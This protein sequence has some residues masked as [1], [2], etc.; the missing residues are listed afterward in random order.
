MKKL[1][2]DRFIRVKGKPLYAKYPRG[3]KLL[4]FGQEGNTWGVVVWRIEEIIDGEGLE[5]EIGYG[6]NELSIVGDYYDGVDFG[7]TEYTVVA[8]QSINPKYGLQYELVSMIDN[9]DLTD[10]FQQR[11][12]LSNF[13]APSI[14]DALYQT[15]ESPMKAIENK[16]RQTLMKVKG[17]GPKIADKIL[18]KYAAHKD[19]SLI[20]IELDEYNFTVSFIK[21]LIDKYHNPR[22]AIAKVKTQPYDLIFELNG[23]GFK[24]A[25]EIAMKG[26]LDPTSPE[27]LKGFIYYY[28]TTE[29]D[30]GNSYVLANEL[31]S[32]IFNYFGGREEI[33]RFVKDEE[34]NIVDN[35]INQALT[36]LQEA[37]I[38]T[39]E[40]NAENK[41][42]RKIYLQYYYDLEKK[43]AFHLKRLLHAPNKFQY[44]HW[45]EAL[46][47]L[48]NKQGWKFTEEQ[49]Q[50]VKLALDSQVAFI[51]GGAGCGK[52]SLVSGVI[53]S[54][55]KYSFQQCSLAGK[56]AAR[57][58]E[59]T[60]QE[61]VTIHRLLKY[62]PIKGGFIH[63]N[64][65]PIV[66]DIIIV[67]EIS[68][69]GGEIFLKLLEAIADGTKL[70][71]LGDMGQ[72]E[73]IGCLNIAADIYN[74]N[75]IPKVEL[76]IIHRQ[77]QKSGIIT[78]SLKV[79][80]EESLFDRG[81]TGERVIG[82]LQDMI[83]I[84]NSSSGSSK[85][86]A[87]EAFKKYYA[88]VDNNIMDVQLISP[89]KERGIACVY[90]LNQ[91][92][93]EIVNPKISEFDPV[94][95]VS[96]DKD[97]SFEIRIDDKVMCIQNKYNLFNEVGSNVDIFNGWT[98]IVKNIDGEY[99]DVYFP[100]PN[101]TVTIAYK[102]AM[103]CLQ[104]GY[105]CTCHKCQGSS[106]KIVIGV[107][108][109]SIPPF[110]KTKELLYT[111]ITRAEDLCI[112][113]GQASALK[114]AVI[115]SGIK[116]KKTFLPY[117]LE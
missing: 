45:E 82:E 52:S 116:N 28:L 112:I 30:L 36:L 106:A 55:D 93:Q 92:I 103:T 46:E 57:L 105:A 16:D 2:N 22:V 61:G 67:D 90:E 96:L 8:K 56:A 97:H 33:L 15:L 64:V 17:V 18:S 88:Q 39:I 70:I 102:D 104:L 54:L 109:N 77:A 21:K 79:R 38:I 111:M 78:S 66:T 65:N 47:A 117:F 98:G 23:V 73:S 68:L 74:S 25:D 19:H 44:E 86:E 4:T 48:E 34:G 7:I 49:K 14:V 20:Y 94:M 35:N 87:I 6:S 110:M 114:E 100:I 13:L 69:V 3:D 31:T 75:T 51:T 101:E 5:Q 71:M 26:G 9:F 72:L 80:R 83:F 115:R 53:A 27:R 50:G 89:T 58:T 42:M 63:D 12:F 85:Y 76:T 37:D 40:E 10:R 60:G 62:D 24:T 59:V 32:K 107:F 1:S 29:A 11:T 81:E 91:S 113:V 84:L 99:V 108:D 43:I 41:S 95:S